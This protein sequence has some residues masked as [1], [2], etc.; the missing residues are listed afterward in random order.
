MANNIY[1]FYS[2]PGHGW[3]RVKIAELRKL[4]LMDKI[5]K[6]SYIN[7]ASAYLEEDC[8]IPKFINAK[9]AINQKLIIKE[10][11]SDSRSSIR[12]YSDFIPD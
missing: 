11:H 3:L 2:D 8:D 12:S 9:T 1:N 4:N 6:Y 10:H 7:G 5:S